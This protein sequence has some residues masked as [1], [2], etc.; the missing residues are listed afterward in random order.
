LR[1]PS[2]EVS[3]GLDC[4]TAVTLSGASNRRVV[5]GTQRKS[6]D[7][8]NFKWK[9]TVL[10]N[11]KSASSGTYHAFKFAK[12]GHCYLAEAQYRFNRRFNLAIIM[13][14]LPSAYGASPPTPPAIQRK[15]W[16]AREPPAVG[17][18]GTTWA[19]M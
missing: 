3:D 4:F 5:V 13:P 9:N 7:L 14:R 2:S 8:A 17:C 18:N 11:L 16:Q 15:T 6:S 10:G 12:Y 1:A 19:S